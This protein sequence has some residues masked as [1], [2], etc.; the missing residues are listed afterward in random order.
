M[1]TETKEKIDKIMD[2][3]SGADGGGSYVL[4]LGLLQ[5]MDRQAAAGD[6]DAQKVI[7][8]TLGPLCRLIDLAKKVALGSSPVRRK[9]S[10]GKKRR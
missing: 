5:D 4:L 3:F 6:E 7:D 10:K 2:T 1:R 9:T 8:N